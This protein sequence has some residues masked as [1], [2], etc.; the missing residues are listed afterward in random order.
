MHGIWQKALVISEPCT[1]APPFRPGIDFVQAPLK[2]I[3]ERIEYYLASPRGREEAQAIA[4]QG[5]Q[6]LT[7]SCRLADFLR[8][9][10]LQLYV[11]RSQDRFWQST[12]S[13]DVAQ[14]AENEMAKFERF[15]FKHPVLP[16]KNHEDIR[17]LKI[18]LIAGIAKADSI[19]DFGGLWGVDGLYMIEGAKALN[20]KYAEMIDVTPR[21]GFW[22]RV[23]ELEAGMRIEV[24]FLCEDFRDP[25]LF[26]S[27]VPV[28]VS[29]LYDVMLH[30]DNPE[31]VIKNALSKTKQYVCLA[32]PV[33]KEEMFTL[34]NGCVNLQFYPEE[35]KDLLRAPGWWPKET[36]VDQRPAYWT[37][38]Q[39][40]SYFKSV[41]YGYGW[42]M[43]HS[44]AYHISRYW[45]YAL[46]RF[47]PRRGSN[48]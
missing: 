20:C 37:W 26:K 40:V 36:I 13:A 22:P 16:P 3:P 32:Q 11:P 15:S 41:F 31:E 2:E 28:D 46:M 24:K 21:E 48:G 42:D 18:E 17:R 39:T 14:T 25:A 45:N 1:L 34:P 38:G 5:F 44:E 27:L 9:L 8:P 19:R 4:L 6:T 23:R 29:I 35:L 33:L 43:E 47:V 10:I 12:I 7:G 30:Q